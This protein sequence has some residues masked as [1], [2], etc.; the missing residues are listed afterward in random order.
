MVQ[1][2]TINRVKAA[3]RKVFVGQAAKGI[4]RVGEDKALLC[5]A[6]ALRTQGAVSRAALIDVFL[7]LYNWGRLRKQP[8][9]AV[10]LK[11]AE[12]V[13]PLDDVDNSNMIFSTSAG[14]GGAWAYLDA[15]DQTA[16]LTNNRFTREIR[17]GIA[18]ARIK[19]K[20]GVTNGS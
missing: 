8:D 13:K 12:L 10:Y 4:D 17:A 19:D 7:T 18:K 1:T 9:E 14:E 6:A 15:I 3:L 20:R 16:T 5:C 11:L 2:V